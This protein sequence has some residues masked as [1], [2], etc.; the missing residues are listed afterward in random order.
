MFYKI[1]QS[2]DESTYNECLTSN[3]PFVGVLNWNEFETKEYCIHLESDI[4]MEAIH[5]SKVEVN[6]STLSGTIFI[7]DRKDMDEQMINCSFVLNKTGIIFIDNL[8]TI[9]LYIEE[10]RRKR[11]RQKPSLERFL[12][13][14]LE[15]IIEDDL[16]ILEAYGDDMELMESEIL[17]GNFDDVIQSL[18][19]IRNQ[20]RSFWIHY[21][22]LIDFGEKLEENEND[23]FDENNLRYFQLFEERVDRRQNLVN[24]LRDHT[25]QIR[26]LYQSQLDVQQ[27]QTMGVLTVVTTVFLPLTLIVGWYGMNFKYM[28]ELQQKWGYPILIVICVIIVILNLWFFR[29]KK[30]L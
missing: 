26:D 19:R 20:L 22:E 2:L 23:I 6:F 27:N 15:M 28:P 1:N 30:L 12:Y 13:D 18:T 5:N 17:A 8:N 29:K 3:T 14:F 7:P 10:M 24:S 21:E 11:K 4:D 16:Q 9:I 25:S